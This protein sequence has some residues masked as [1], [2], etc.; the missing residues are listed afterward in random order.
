MVNT[1]HHTSTADKKKEIY[2]NREP[3]RDQ[4]LRVFFNKILLVSEQKHTVAFY[5]SFN[6]AS[7]VGLNTLFYYVSCQDS[8]A[9]QLRTLVLTVRLQ[10]TWGTLVCRLRQKIRRR[11]PVTT[12][13]LQLTN[14]KK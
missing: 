12:K 4:Y 1:K 8:F 5:L 9:F 13:A 2:R 11:T 7:V 10:L 14:S 3:C 6:P